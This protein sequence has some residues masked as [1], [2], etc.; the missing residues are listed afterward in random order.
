MQRTGRAAPC[1]IIRYVRADTSG[2]P[3]DTT[4]SKNIN[5]NSILKLARGL[6]YSH[7]TLLTPSPRRTAM[8]MIAHAPTNAV[9]TRWSADGLIAA[10]PPSLRHF[11]FQPPANA[12]VLH[13]PSRRL[14]DAR[15]TSRTVMP[16]FRV[17]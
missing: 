12:A 16:T 15:F 17:F 9:N 1:P 10:I 5:K 3:A 7:Q 11:A 14:Q 13:R 2:Q 6:L 4:I 8:H